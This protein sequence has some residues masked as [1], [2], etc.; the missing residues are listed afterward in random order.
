MNTHLWSLNKDGST[1]SHNRARQ[2]KCCRNYPKGG[3]MLPFRKQRKVRWLKQLES[4][5]LLFSSLI[6]FY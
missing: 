3:C 5:P 4:K 1:K 2:C 6:R